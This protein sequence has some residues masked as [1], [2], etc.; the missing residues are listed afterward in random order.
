MDTAIDVVVVGAGQAG[1]AASHHLSRRGIEHAV[2][3][4]GRV[5]ETWRSQ[6]W[7]SFA[8][9][10]P[11]WMSRLPGEAGEAHGRD[12][13][14]SAREWV[15]RL[16]AAVAR[17]RVP[18]RA[19]TN[20]LSVREDRRGGF[21]VAA[22]GSGGVEEI[23]A[24]AVVVASGILNV[25]RI[26]PFAE[27]LPADVKQFTAASYRG[28]A[29]LPPGCVLVV[30]GAQSG[31]QIAEEIRLAGRDVHLATSAAPRLRRRYRGRDT[32]EWLALAGFWDLTP[33][34]LPDPAM[35]SWPNPQTSGVGP[36]GHTVS[37]QGLALLGV[38]LLGRPQSIVGGRI[39]LSDTL[40][41]SVAFADRTARQLI[42]LADRAI[43]EAGMDAPPVEAD[44]DDDPHPDPESM[45]SPAA[46]DLAAA[47]I[48]SVIWTTG[49]TGDF[50]YLP[51]AALDDAGQPLHTGVLGPLP[52]LYHIGY[53]WLRRRKSGI[54]FGLDDDAAVVADAVAGGLAGK[55]GRK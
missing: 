25:P 17:D 3:E 10:T 12:T 26:P 50:A 52:G 51:E 9:N 31:V 39:I 4:R 28:P 8:L 30:G 1:V 42:A 14:M 21:V 33:D 46:I 2:L 22:A 36:L 13:F 44:P 37:L 35:L 23:H 5:G 34:Q 55:R 7:D 53:P 16:E 15:S 43:D 11:R 6:R 38:R 32:F 29:A 47:G 27:S 54:I 19:G 24:R 40:G 41:A 48:A 20:V 49:F 18:V 45:H